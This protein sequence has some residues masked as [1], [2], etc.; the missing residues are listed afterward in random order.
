[1]FDPG[2]TTFPPVRAPCWSTFRAGPT[3]PGGVTGRHGDR[4]GATVGVPAS[5]MA[6]T[7]TSQMA[8]GSFTCY[9]DRLVRV[10]FLTSPL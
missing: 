8:S 2:E 10:T 9:A 5:P 1:L 6:P 4:N 3:R 7:A